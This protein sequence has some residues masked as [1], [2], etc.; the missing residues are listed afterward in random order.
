MTTEHNQSSKVKQPEA[1]TTGDVSAHLYS[2]VA[3]IRSFLN[4]YGEA[5][6]RGLLIAP[7]WA[8]Y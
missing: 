2:L 8:D 3:S 6:R 1:T 4:V 7:P 5:P